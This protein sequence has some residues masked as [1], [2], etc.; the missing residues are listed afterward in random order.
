MQIL[1][2]SLEF[3]SNSNLAYVAGILEDSRPEIKKWEDIQELIEEQISDIVL[4]V[5]NQAQLNQKY[6]E[7]FDAM[8]V[9]QLIQVEATS[10]SSE[11]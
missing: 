5:K 6:K 10:V 2:A 4:N 9:K 11:T 8:A 3:K 7:L 1:K